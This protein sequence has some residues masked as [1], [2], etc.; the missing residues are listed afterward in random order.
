[1]KV[2]L[3]W[4]REL[5]PGLPDDVALLGATLND[6]GH[7]VE[8]IM[9]LHAPVPGVVVARVLDVQTEP[10]RKVR[11]VWVD[12]GDG[13]RRHVWCGADNMAVDDLV[14]LATIGT[15]MPSGMQIAEREMFGA[16]SQGMLCSQRELGLGDDHGG[17]WILPAGLP[18]GA[19][20]LAATGR[21]PDVL[22]DLDVPRNRP[23]CWGHLGIAR[24]LAARLQ[25]PFA[26]PDPAVPIAG[27]STGVTVRIEA[28]E[29][30]GRFTARA[31]TGIRITPSPEWVADRL[32]KA[33]M[34]AINN[35]VDA[36]NL[37]MLELGRPN[38]TYDRAKVGGDG[39]VIR[40]ARDGEV[41][42]TLDDVAR[43]LTARDCVIGDAAG[44]AHGLGGIMG[45]EIGEI[46]DTTTDVLL[47]QA[48][49]DPPSIGASAG[50]LGLRTEASARFE[51]GCDPYDDD[52]GARRL[53][54]VLRETCPDIALHGVVADEGRL[55]DRTPITVRTARVNAILGTD[56]S[57]DDIAALLDPIGFAPVAA[58]DDVAVTIPSWRVD[59]SAEID[60][61]EEVAR[62]YGY[63]RIVKTVPRP[64]QPGSL[65]VR[66]KDRRR[67]R[68]V[69]V[70]LGCAEAMPNTFL[71]PADLT[72][73]G[74]DADGLVVTNPLV[75]D[76][77]MLRTSLLPG[78]LRAVALNESHRQ[79]GVRLFEIGH[80]YRH[81]DDATAELPDE[82]AMLAVAL[83]GHEA[84]AAVATLDEIVA[85]LGFGAI[86][87]TPSTCP[88]LHPTRTALVG[89]VGVVGEVDPAVLEAW[90]ITERVA[91]LEL[92][93]D[94]L[95]D[96]PHGDRPA[97]PVLRMP[98]ADI[99]LAFA[100]PTAITAAQVEDAL[101]AGG[102]ELLVDL[103]LFDVY[104]TDAS[105]PS[106]SLAFRL[107]FQAADRTLTD[108]DLT[109]VRSACITAVE[110]LGASLRG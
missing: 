1:V 90:S 109:A 103:R 32:T 96:L 45:A 10:K 28:P 15:T 101:R 2:L 78:L 9:H 81:G 16:V 100:V 13:E 26:P 53:V 107:R 67:L 70:G 97:R 77:S 55:P 5:C 88:G 39:F 47:E 42:V 59:S 38:H 108:A 91:W 8:E 46:D 106:R 71:A 33:G 93:L 104:R 61:I 49:F 11:H 75:A 110:R 52:M 105:S 44:V 89:D 64:P 51:R 94:A 54:Q 87:L 19:D 40:A 86:A 65:S 72:R 48:W 79:M 58:G 14:A 95:L 30:C 22:F 50:R 56:L 7:A 4:L 68:A 43:T 62:Q 17:I 83:A 85:A 23:D 27:P 41:L 69:L 24:D 102:G 31:I 80:T 60:V 84:P 92:D 99:D 3:S 12:A 66:Q 35:V 76:E 37:V 34:R 25:V 73:S 29:L 6:L 57:R 82:R 98:S 36:S 20:V 21:R 63:S 18:L 74:L